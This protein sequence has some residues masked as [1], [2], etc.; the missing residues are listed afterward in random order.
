MMN[1][2]THICG[3]MLDL[4]LTNQPD[5]IINIETL[6]NFANSDH[7]ILIAEVIFKPRQKLSSELVCD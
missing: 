4:V 7:T 3:N 2:K 1:F 6:G 5:F